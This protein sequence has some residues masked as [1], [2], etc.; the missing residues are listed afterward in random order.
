[1]PLFLLILIFIVIILL[2]PTLFHLHLTF[3]CLFLV[4]HNFEN[5]QKTS[6]SNIDDVLSMFEQKAP[7][8]NIL[9]P[10]F[11]ILIEI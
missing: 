10:L 6:R 9:P 8:T 5:R 2:L 7:I 11:E 1:M 4:S 3:L